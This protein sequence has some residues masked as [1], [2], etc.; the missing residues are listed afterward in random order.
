MRVSA[1]GI[2]LDSLREQS[3]G[4]IHLPLHAIDDRQITVSRGII[5]G[6]FDTFFAS[7]NCL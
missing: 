4:L 1:I 3:D 2:D 7:G 5:G 6:Q